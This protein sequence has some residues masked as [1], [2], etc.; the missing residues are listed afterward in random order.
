MEAKLDPLDRLF[1]A[2]DESR[3]VRSDRYHL[4]GGQHFRSRLEQH[5]LKTMPALTM[6]FVSHEREPGTHP[7]EG[8]MTLAVAHQ[9]DDRLPLTC[10]DCVRGGGCGSVGNLRHGWFSIELLVM[11]IYRDYRSDKFVRGYRRLI[12]AGG[13]RLR[14]E[15]VPA[16]K[17]LHSK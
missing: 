15:P 6:S 1:E 13:L 4:R 5:G 11:E 16:R 2:L 12:P 14:G 9:A 7:L 10:D 17:P 8:R 3:C